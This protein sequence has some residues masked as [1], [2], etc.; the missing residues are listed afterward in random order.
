MK[1]IPHKKG[2]HMFYTFPAQHGKQCHTQAQVSN[3]PWAP[4]TNMDK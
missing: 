1:Y 4:F 3:T 2:Q